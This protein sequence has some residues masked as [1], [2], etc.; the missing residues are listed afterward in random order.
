MS[1]KGL[2]YL[3]QILHTKRDER[4]I[5][6]KWAICSLFAL[7]KSKFFDCWTYM[8][9]V[10]TAREQSSAANQTAND[11]GNNCSVQ[12]GHIHHFKLMWIRHQL[13]ACVINDHIIVFDIWILFRHTTWHL[14][15]QTVG[16]FHNIGFVNSGDLCAAS[17]LCWSF[18]KKMLNRL[19][20]W[21]VTKYIQWFTH[22]IQMH[23]EPHA[24]NFHQW[25][26]SCSQLRL[27]H[28]E[29]WRKFSK[30]T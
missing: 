30:I 5:V 29:K 3:A 26:L 10:V 9:T 14:Q 12:I 7:K 27:E 28:S 18:D 19:V 8:I 13:H 6:I 4:T 1:I 2:N 20:K 15:E 22:H 25:Q 23:N 17:T 21:Y 16:Y 24:P 11:I